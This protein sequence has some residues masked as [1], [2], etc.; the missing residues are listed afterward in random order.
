MKKT[1]F[2]GKIAAL[3]VAVLAFSACLRVQVVRNVD[4]PDPYFDRAYREIDRLE[5]EDPGRL[6]DAHELCLLAYDADDGELVRVHMG[7]WLVRTALSLGLDAAEDD[8]DFRDWEGR[9]EFDLG[10]LRRLD[11]FGPGPLLEVE[12]DRERLLIWLR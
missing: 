2:P 8:R 7:L 9:Y 6:G 10:V 5:R 11:G 4:N 12:E 1:V 3:A